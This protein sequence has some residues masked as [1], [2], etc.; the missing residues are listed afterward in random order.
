MTGLPFI[1]FDVNET[2]RQ[3][4][5]ILRSGNALL[6]VGPQPQIS[7]ADL[8]EVAATLIARYANQN[9]AALG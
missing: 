2:L 8:N 1:V 6:E 9:Q 3:A 5:L 4:A 7:G